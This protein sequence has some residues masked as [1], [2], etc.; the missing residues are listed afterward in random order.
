MGYKIEMSLFVLVPLF[1]AGAAY[2]HY[3]TDV[4]NKGMRQVYGKKNST[5]SNKEL[6]RD[7]TAP[8]NE[9][10]A[11][12]TVHT[13]FY[14]TFDDSSDQERLA[15]AGL[16]PE[17]WLSALQPGNM[18]TFRWQFY[19]NTKPLSITNSRAD[20]LKHVNTRAYR[21]DGGPNGEVLADPVKGVMDMITM[22]RSQNIRDVYSNM[23][24]GHMSTPLPS[25]GIKALTGIVPNEHHIFASVVPT[26]DAPASKEYE[27]ADK[28][29]VYYDQYGH[30]SSTPFTATRRPTDLQYYGNPWGAGGAFHEH[31]QKGGYR[32][33]GYGGPTDRLVIPANQ[34]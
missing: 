10:I 13:E 1:V 24:S 20:R 12:D 8:S 31:Y 5:S 2:I 3:A 19:G 26:P 30:M 16:Y 33:T 6:F 25:P 32:D 15:K 29:W 21:A 11:Y 18:N 9:A 27:N 34:E 17:K 14:N 28:T 4:H 7:I 22:S 23:R